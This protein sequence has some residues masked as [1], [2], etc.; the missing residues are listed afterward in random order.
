MSIN[1]IETEDLRRMEDKEGLILQGCGGEPGEWVKGINDL[2]TQD[3]IL[4]G[5]TTFTHVSVFQ[6][7]DLTCLLFPFEDVML[8]IG[9][10]AMWRLQTHETFGGTW[11]SDF[12]PNRLG[13]FIGEPAPEP[14]KPDCALIGQDGNI[15]NLVGI[16]ERTLREHGLTD[17]AKEMKDRVFASGSYGEA[18]CIIG[19]Y[20]NIT[21]TEP[22]Q[23]PSLRQQ[24]KETKTAEPSARLKPEKQQER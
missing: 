22:E 23:R 4:L 24:L 3:G 7:E 19:E 16:A 15:F 10:L 5:G 11:L 6:N 14:E 1:H 8:D 13:G 20:V 17:Q 21:D 18:L 2:L 9:K 12:V